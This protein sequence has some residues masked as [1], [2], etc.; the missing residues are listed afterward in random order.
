MRIQGFT[1]AVGCHC[2]I[3][4][5]TYLQSLCVLTSDLYAYLPPIWFMIR[6]LML[7]TGALQTEQ[8][9]PATNEAAT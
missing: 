2:E 6:V 7:S 4:M 5:C 9:K 8:Q 1:E 3:F